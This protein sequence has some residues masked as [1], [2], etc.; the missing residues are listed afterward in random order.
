MII[1]GCDIGLDGAFA[2]QDSDTGR[3]L[4]A[5]NTPTLTL[6]RGGK[7]KREIDIADLITTLGHDVIDGRVIPRNINQAFVEQVSS[8]PG[9]GVSGVFAFGKAYGIVL[10]VLGTLEIPITLASPQK[11]KKALGVPA[12]KDGARARASQLLPAHAELWTPRRGERNAIQAA[13]IAEAALIAEWGRRNLE[14]AAA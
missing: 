10:G 11:W 6:K 5:W 7:T 1:L 4:A 2:I 13:G 8:M 12:A 9:Q 14:R 3:I